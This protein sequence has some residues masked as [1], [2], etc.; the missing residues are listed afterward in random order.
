LVIG[1]TNLLTDAVNDKECGKQREIPSGSCRTR[2]DKKEIFG[3]SPKTA[4][5]SRALPGK[6]SENPQ[7]YSR[8]SSRFAKIFLDLL[9][10]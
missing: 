2:N 10:K 5:E 1:S 8:N 3:E 6:K 7:C 9:C 4:R